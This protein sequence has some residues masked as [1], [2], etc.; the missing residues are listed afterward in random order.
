MCCV[1]SNNPACLLRYATETVQASRQTRTAQRRAVECGVSRGESSQ[2]TRASR[3]AHALACPPSSV[4]TPGLC[5]SS[6]LI[7]VW[8]GRVCYLSDSKSCASLSCSI[9][10]T[11]T[12]CHESTLPACIVACS[13]SEM[14]RDKPAALPGN[15]P[16]SGTRTGGSV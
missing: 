4:R 8:R 16:S 10:R 12:S 15:L 7:A 9:L 2:E 11:C 3:Q 14:V 5:P 13:Y 1:L 6:A